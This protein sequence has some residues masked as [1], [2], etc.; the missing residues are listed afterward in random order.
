MKNSVSVQKYDRLS[1]F[2]RSAWVQLNQ[3]G[4]TPDAHQSI[5]RLHSA[6]EEILAADNAIHGDSTLGSA[7]ARY[8]HSFLKSQQNAPDLLRALSV[9]AQEIKCNPETPVE[10]V[11]DALLAHSSIPVIWRMIRSL[12]HEV[13]SFRNI[14][15]YMRLTRRLAR[16]MLVLAAVFVMAKLT[17]FAL[18]WGCLISYYE[19]SENPKSIRGWNVATALVMDYDFGRPLPW[20]RRDGWSAR[21]KGM[22]LVPENSEYFFF[23]QCEGGLRLWLDE[24]LLIDNWNSAGWRNGGPN[25]HAR[26]VLQAGP[27]ALRMEFRDR[28]GESALRVRWTGGP[29]PPD[30]VIGFPYL[31]K[32]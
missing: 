6:L 30:T 14:P 12:R 31:R 7:V 4:D 17:W 15:Y 1:D 13:R 10:N 21:W 16:G 19:S 27:H 26:R 23:G 29:I 22:L 20:M 9:R 3:A 32:Y 2:V 24:E 5:L 18:P 28:G 25:Q 11:A 8:H